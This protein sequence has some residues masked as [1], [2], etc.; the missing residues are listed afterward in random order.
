MG[1]CGFGHVSVQCPDWLHQKQ[2]PVGGGVGGGLK[3]Q[4]GM[5]WARLILLAAAKEAY[6]AF[7][8]QS[9]SLSASSCLL[10]NI[11]R[12]NSRRSLWGESQG[13]F[14]AGAIFGEYQGLT[15]L[16]TGHVGTEVQRAWKYLD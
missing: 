15:G 1:G 9:F 12:A 11:L 8:S 10:L 4:S 16:R 5:T 14:L 3:F 2:G 6:L 7:L 13:P